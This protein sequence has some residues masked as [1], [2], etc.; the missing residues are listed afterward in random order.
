MNANRM[1][2]TANLNFSVKPFEPRQQ[3]LLIFFLH[4]CCVWEGVFLSLFL[5]NHR[6]FFSY[7]VNYVLH[8]NIKLL[9]AGMKKTYITLLYASSIRGVRIKSKTTFISTIG[10]HSINITATNKK[11]LSA[12]SSTNIQT[13]K[14]RIIMLN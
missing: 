10:H 11:L 6:L 12:H 9:T 3:S 13:V 1:E 4:L 7:I 5:Q 8:C 14:H 2:E